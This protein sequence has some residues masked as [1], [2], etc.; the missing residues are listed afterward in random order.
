MPAE[1]TLVLASSFP[2]FDG[3][4]AGVFVLEMA[5]FYRTLGPV[6]VLAPDDRA[7]DRAWRP[8][9]LAVRRFALEPLLELDPDCVIPGVGAAADCLER[10]LDQ[11]LKKIA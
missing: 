8:A 6:S 9:G 3:D 2:R 1:G 4:W 5:E 10:C 11:P 7:V